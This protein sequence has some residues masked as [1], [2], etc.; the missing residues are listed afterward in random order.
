M[1]SELAQFT[2]EYNW[3]ELRVVGALKT[4]TD[5]KPFL[6]LE[7][8]DTRRAW[9]NARLTLALLKVHMK[10]PATREKVMVQNGVKK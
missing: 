5:I 7:D 10:D 9:L 3:A 2:R 6:D 4:V 8:D 1:P